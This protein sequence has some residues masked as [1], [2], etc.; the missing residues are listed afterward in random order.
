MVSL[1]KMRI[2]WSWRR[3]LHSILILGHC[4]M[5]IDLKSAIFLRGWLDT[6]RRFIFGPFVCGL[7]T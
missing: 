5:Y 4:G 7:L 1:A 3:F 2:L 6:G